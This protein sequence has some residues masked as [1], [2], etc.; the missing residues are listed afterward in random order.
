MKK[1]STILILLIIAIACTEQIPSNNDEGQNSIFVGQKLYNDQCVICHGKDLNK[2]ETGPKLANIT[3]YRTKE[4]LRDFT[5]N[6]YKMIE[7][8]DSLA[9]CNW[10]LW[11][12]SIMSS[13]PYLTNEDIDNIYKFIEHETK[14]LGLDTI[15]PYD[16]KDFNIPKSPIDTQ[17]YEYTYHGDF[18]F[19]KYGSFSFT[20]FLKYLDLKVN[21]PFE[22]TVNEDIDY[23][24]Y[25]LFEE[26]GMI[27]NQFEV[28]NNVGK[29]TTYNSNQPINLPLGEK[30]K[31]IAFSKD[32][33]RGT[34]VQTKIKKKNNYTL[35]LKPFKT[36]YKDFYEGL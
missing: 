5:K 9:L 25:L 23:N 34:V 14:R 13:Y 11:Q 35:T 26:R 27:T 16:C 33:K 24:L 36:S 31:I 8:G 29:L 32:R 17:T 12:P 22:I 4:W 1:L 10:E 30:V 7:K 18:L 2:D 20:E 28:G 21:T 6:P 15:K 3:A 19:R